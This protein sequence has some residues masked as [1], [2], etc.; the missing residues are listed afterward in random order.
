MIKKD[1]IKTVIAVADVTSILILG[2]L[3]LKVYMSYYAC[4]RIFDTFLTIIPL[5]IIKIGEMLLLKYK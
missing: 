1:T 5:I 3:I 4:F 2:Y